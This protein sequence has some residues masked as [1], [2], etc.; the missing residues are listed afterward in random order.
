MLISLMLGDNHDKGVGADFELFKIGITIDESV[1][2][3]E[4]L[5]NR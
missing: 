2:L 1:S 3:R 4:P 5:T